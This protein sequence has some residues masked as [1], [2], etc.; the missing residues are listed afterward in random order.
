ML[1]PQEI[2]NITVQARKNI[3]ICER[4]KFG[5]CGD[6]AKETVK[7]LNS[8]KIESGYFVYNLPNEEQSEHSWIRIGRYVLDPTIDQ[9]FSDLDVDL[10]TKTYGIYFSHPSWDGDWLLNRY[11]GRGW[12]NK[13]FKEWLSRNY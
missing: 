4:A 3:E 1:S 11:R 6:A 9:F 13:S 10:E 5:D 8:G 12:W 2:V 7:L